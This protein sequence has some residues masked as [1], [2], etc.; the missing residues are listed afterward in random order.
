MRCSRRKPL[1][2]DLDHP[3]IV[4]YVG[5]NLSDHADEEYSLTFVR[6]WA[7]AV[8]RQVERVREISKKKATDSRNYDRIEDWSPTEEDIQRN[9]RSAW[10]E[11]HTLVWAAHQLE[12]WSQRLASDGGHQ[13]L[14]ADPVLKRVRDALERLDDA[15]FTDLYA[16]PGDVG[17]RNRSLRAL[18]GSRLMIAVGGEL[19]FSLIT[20]Q[21]LEGRALAVVRGIGDELEQSGLDRYLAMLED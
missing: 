14:E 6:T 1:V 20:A 8:L 17:K 19:A 12:Q 4:V 3:F 15:E 7:E 21:E 13:P 9:F 2:E 10:A 18:P 16:V 5:E 11:Q